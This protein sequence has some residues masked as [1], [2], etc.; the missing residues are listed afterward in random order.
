MMRTVRPKLAKFSDT[1]GGCYRATFEMHLE[2][3]TV[4]EWNSTLRK[5]ICSWQIGREVRWELRLYSLVN[6]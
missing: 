3:I 5:S 1:L 2:D 6:V 4:Q